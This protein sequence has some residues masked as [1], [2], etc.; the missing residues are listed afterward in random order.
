MQI[1]D[2]D[3]SYGSTSPSETRIDVEAKK[4]LSA[5]NY[6]HTYILTFISSP[7]SLRRLN[8]RSTRR[9]KGYLMTFC[10]PPRYPIDHHNSK[11][12]TYPSVPSHCPTPISRLVYSSRFNRSHF[13]RPQNLTSPLQL[14]VVEPTL[15]QKKFH[16]DS[17]HF[18]F[19]A[20]S[21]HRLMA[22]VSK[23][24]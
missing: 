12:V 11:T 24:R 20:S 14:F 16:L 15:L 19:Q 1:L 21:F 13:L 4:S 5:D 9:Y 7:I 6:Q 18:P 23:N 22:I 2:L 10:R 17:C 8:T 3:I